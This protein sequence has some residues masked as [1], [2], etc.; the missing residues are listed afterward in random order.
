MK[1]LDASYWE[2]RYQENATGWDLGEISIPLKTYLDGLTDHSLKILVPGAGNGHEVAYA[3]AQGFSHITMLDF[4]RSPL[5][6]FHRLHPDF[7]LNQLIQDDFFLHQGQYD[8]ILEQTFFC[9]IDRT[10]RPAYVKHMHELL[11]PGGQLVGVLFGVELTVE[12]PPYGGSLLEYKGLF[13]PFFKVKKL[14]LC[15]NSITPRKDNELF[16]ILERRD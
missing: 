8:L 6:Q 16:M 4:A 14:E 12:G 15:H 2:K 7:P 13:E 11:R 10:L 9:A 5:D 1:N 3:Y